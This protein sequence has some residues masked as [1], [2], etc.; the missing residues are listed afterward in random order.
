MPSGFNTIIG[1]NA[2]Y[3]SGGQ[4]Q[5]IALAR[6]FY[7]DQKILVL[8]ESTNS[9]D[10]KTEYEILK[11]IKSKS[12]DTTVIIIFHQSKTLNICNKILNI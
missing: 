5:R 2:A 3:L 12:S 7:S 4:A 11:Y 6:A 1:E 8:D 10:T 9:L